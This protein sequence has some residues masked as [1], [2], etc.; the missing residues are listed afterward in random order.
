MKL[1]DPKVLIFA[2]AATLVGCSSDESGGR[3]QPCTGCILIGTTPSAYT[4][5]LDNNMPELVTAR[6]SR[7]SFTSLSLSVGDPTQIGVTTPTL[8][9]AEA[10]FSV[11]PIAHNY[12]AAN[13]GNTV[14][15]TDSSGAQ[16]SVGIT[17]ASCGRPASLLAAQQ[18]V[19]ASGATGTS[20]S[21]GTVYFVAYFLTGV[22]VNGSLHMAVG[23]HGTL[24]G[25]PLVAASPPPGTSLPTPIPLPDAT[26]IVVSATVPMLTAGQT[27]QTQLYNDTCQAPVIAGAFAT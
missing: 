10:T 22:G 24:E 20:T 12:A 18:I 13:P 19:P 3:P 21:V 1:A 15:L 25:G 14:M 26:D 4:F 17:T 9:G 6:M 2:C 8:S 23:A 27:Y 16:G 11:I 5:P 7:G